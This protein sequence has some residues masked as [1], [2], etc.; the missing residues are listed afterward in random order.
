MLSADA[1]DFSV[2]NL[3]TP[4]GMSRHYHSINTSSTGVAPASAP[5]RGMGD[6]WS[7]TYSDM[8]IFNEDDSITWFT[9][10]GISLN[11]VKQHSSYITPSSVFGTLVYNGTSYVWTDTT[12]G[13]MTWDGSGRLVSILDRYKDGVQVSYTV[14]TTDI[15]E[16]QRVLNGV[17]ESSEGYLKFTYNSSWHITAITDFDSASDTTGRTWLYGYDSSGQLASVTA[18]IVGTEPLSM[19][20]TPTTPTRPTPA[21]RSIF[22]EIRY[23]RGRER[24][25]VHLLRQPPRLPSDRCA[26]RH[27]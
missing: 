1:T 23:R 12:G 16:V 8:L 9:D 15:N 13:T 5:D 10:T 2:P 4:L 22:V 18:P 11:F 7:F 17:V 20:D 14:G 24:D 25:D 27:A 19:T 3:G 21:R 26:G 6:G